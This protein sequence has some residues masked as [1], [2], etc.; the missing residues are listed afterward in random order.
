MAMH[1]TFSALAGSIVAPVTPPEAAIGR[2]PYAVAIAVASVGC[3]LWMRVNGEL[4]L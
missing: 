4:P 2:L 3:V 1:T